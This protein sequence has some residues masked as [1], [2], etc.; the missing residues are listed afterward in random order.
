[1]NKGGK[2]LD[3]SE[4]EV[5]IIVEDYEP[6]ST[7]SNLSSVQFG[8]QYTTIDIVIWLQERFLLFKHIALALND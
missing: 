1:M 2:R 5:I 8:K 6:A 3:N 4:D 7:H